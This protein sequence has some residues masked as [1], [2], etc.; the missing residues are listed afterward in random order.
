MIFTLIGMP[1]SGKSCMGK[2]IS[3]KMK[4]PLID[5]DKMIEKRFGKKLQL[6]LDELGVVEFRRVEEEVLLSVS[7]DEGKDYILST[8][9]SAVYSERGMLHL[10]SLGKIIYLYC[11]SETIIDRIDNPTDRG[12]V[13]KPGQS[14]IDLYYERIPL[15][16][17][18][19]DFTISCDGRAYPRYQRA[20]MGC[21]SNV[22]SENMK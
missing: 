18:Y 6:I 2:Y 16:E 13:L 20:L 17:R 14:L 15:Y 12:I 11:S 3:N 9:G 22:I 10:K 4:L 7:C 1:G 21:I 19:A 8:G 5:T